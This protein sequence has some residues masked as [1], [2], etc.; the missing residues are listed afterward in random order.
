MPQGVLHRPILSL[1]SRR[2]NSHSTS[3]TLCSHLPRTRQAE[4][5]AKELRDYE[6]RVEPDANERYGGFPVGH[7]DELVTALGLAVQVDPIRWT[8][9]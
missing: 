7:Y 5:L 1:G 8:I 6:V 9:L 4:T 2:A 3:A